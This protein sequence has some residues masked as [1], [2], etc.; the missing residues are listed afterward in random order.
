VVAVHVKPGDVI[1]KGQTLAVLEAMKMEFQLS[2]PVGGIGESVGVAAG[3]Q[4]KN[5]TLLVQ[6]KPKA[7]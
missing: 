3:T 2:L 6:V 4:V 5:K 1:E 7:S